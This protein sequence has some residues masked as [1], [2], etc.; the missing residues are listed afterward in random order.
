MNQ[1]APLQ[2]GISRCLLGE[3]VRY[4]GGHKSLAVLDLL[5]RRVC[6][7]AVC[8]EVEAGLGVPRPPMHL[9]RGPLGVRLREVETPGRDHTHALLDRARRRIPELAGLSGFVFKS[10]SPSCGLQDVPVF[11]EGGRRAAAGSGLFAA[12]LMDCRPGLPV[13][14]DRALDG[15]RAVAEFLARVT[16]YALHR[17]AI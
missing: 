8:P 9:V 10:R 4:D 1:R 16:A 6:L 15:E 2:V 14:E 11:D 7:V 5:R 17:D 3:A 12:H 13:I